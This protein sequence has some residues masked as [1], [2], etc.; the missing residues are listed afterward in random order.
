MDREGVETF[1]SRRVMGKPIRE[2]PEAEVQKVK[3]IE[4]SI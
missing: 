4:D 3:P 1:P 2:S